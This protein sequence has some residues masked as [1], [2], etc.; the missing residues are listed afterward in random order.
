MADPDAVDDAHLGE[1]VVSSRSIHRGSYLRFR[2]D[3]IRDVRGREGTREIVEH[4]GAVALLAVIE[5]DLLL[6]K[7]FRSPIRRV[8][9]EIP[10]G[11]LDRR[12]DGS[13]EPPDEAAQRELVEETGY[14]AAQ[15]RRLGSFFTAPGF[16]DEEIHLYLARGLDPVTDY[17]GPPE[18]ERIDLV[19]LPIADAQ[20]MAAD[21]LIRDA[22]SLVGLAWLER[23]AATGEL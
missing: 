16:T 5:D 11:T 22:K 3:T 23:L 19:R 6:V 10:A 14:R 2:V 9:L 7:Q 13:S 21:G 12:T 15:L 20:R 4:P 18:E 8:L 17:A 1:E